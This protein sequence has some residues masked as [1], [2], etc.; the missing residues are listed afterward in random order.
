MIRLVG[1]KKIVNRYHA[2]SGAVGLEI[3]GGQGNIF[4]GMSL[5]EPAQVRI[6]KFPPTPR[7]AN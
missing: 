1:V 7:V 3:V 4:R 2:V 6:H 5:L